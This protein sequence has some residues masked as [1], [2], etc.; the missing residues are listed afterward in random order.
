MSL[1]HLVLCGLTIITCLLAMIAI[2]ARFATAPYWSIL[3]ALCSAAL[4]S[5]VGLFSIPGLVLS[6]VA[7]VLACAFLRHRAESGPDETS[8]SNLRRIRPA[9]Y[10]FTDTG[11]WRLHR[12]VEYLSQSGVWRV[13]PRDLSNTGTWPARHP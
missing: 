9:E 10:D 11:S 12:P 3:A 1:L 8:T 4:F 5:Q 2:A 7:I 6:V 13:G